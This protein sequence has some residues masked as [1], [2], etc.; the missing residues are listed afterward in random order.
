MRFAPVS[1]RADPVADSLLVQF[2]GIDC[3]PLQA[4]TGVLE[5]GVPN[6]GAHARDD[7]R[8]VGV[9]AQHA[10]LQQVTVAG[11]HTRIAK[12]SCRHCAMG[13]RTA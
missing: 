4:A 12:S 1:G 8:I 5:T 10:S 11:G 7:H 6:T 9:D 2:L 13:L 3:R